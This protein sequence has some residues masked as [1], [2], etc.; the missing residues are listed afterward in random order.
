MR[1][2]LT[3][4]IFPVWRIFKNL[5]KR[6]ILIVGT[7]SLIMVILSFT[8]LPF[9]GYFWLGTSLG[10]S[11]AEPEYIVMLGGSAMP[12]RSTLI[13]IYYASEA[14][15]RYPG[16]KIIISLPGDITDS[17]SSLQITKR[18]LE[19][20]G[21]SADRI[22]TESKGT[23]TRY[24]ALELKRLVSDPY[25]PVLVVT[26]PDHMRRAILTIRKEGFTDVA[27]LPAFDGVNDFSL[28]F[29]DAELGGNRFLPQIGRNL[30]IRYQVWQQ[31]EYELLIARECLALSFYFLKGWI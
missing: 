10:G 13:R 26:S 17:L 2:S 6:L 28:F 5:F 22:L 23:N 21:V 24:Q 30:T 16:A 12:G 8:S 27:G 15:H 11:S 4:Y 7:V 29:R 14:A 18:E 19:I 25:A 9:W 20:R 31:L 3:K 1:I